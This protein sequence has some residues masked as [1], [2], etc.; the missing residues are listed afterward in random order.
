MF[1]EFFKNATL[2]DLPMWAMFGFLAIFVG[3]VFWAMSRRQA[4]RFESLSRMPLDD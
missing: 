1:K 4:A 3:I 2:L